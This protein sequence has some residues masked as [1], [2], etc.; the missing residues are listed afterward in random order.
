MG[1]EL[2]NPRRFLLDDRLHGG[3]TV[4]QAGPFLQDGLGGDGRRAW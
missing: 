4:E 1:P 2:V 3:L